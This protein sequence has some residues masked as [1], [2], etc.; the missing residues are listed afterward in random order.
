MGGRG[1]VN[2]EA[3]QSTTRARKKEIKVFN[4]NIID[5]SNKKGACCIYI[6][7]YFIVK[8][9]YKGSTLCVR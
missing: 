5:I 9:N 3:Q 2:D 8:I 6:V 1:T 4:K 7:K